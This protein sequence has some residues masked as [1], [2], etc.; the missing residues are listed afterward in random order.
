VLS[1]YLAAGGRRMDGWYPQL[2]VVE[3]LF[4]DA[5]AFRNINTLDELRRLDPARPPCAW[6]T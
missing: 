5:D 2:K 4:E 1:A 6:P 3:V